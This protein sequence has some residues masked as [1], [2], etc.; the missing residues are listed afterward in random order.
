MYFGDEAAWQLYTYCSIIHVG[1]EYPLHSILL[2]GQTI[3]VRDN[4]W[5]FINYVASLPKL[6]KISFWIDALCID[7]QDIKDR[8][9]QVRQMGEIYARAEKVIVWLGIVSDEVDAFASALSRS[10]VNG[11]RLQPGDIRALPFCATS[12]VAICQMPYWTRTWI[13]QE[14]LLARNVEVVCNGHYF[15]L[16]ALSN[17][18]DFM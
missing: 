6:K 3:Q 11:A 1:L 15:P 12:T 7:Q 13:V 14:V 10:C 9:K 2:D 16:A 5:Q 18:I 17:V 8:N 4:L